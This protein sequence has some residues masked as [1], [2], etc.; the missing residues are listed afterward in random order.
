MGLKLPDIRLTGEEKPRKNLT[1]ET[2]P[3]RGSNPGP[4][5]DKRACYHLFH[6][7]GRS[8]FTLMHKL[9]MML[10]NGSTVSEM[11]SWKL[12]TKGVQSG[13]L[14]SPHKYM[15]VYPTHLF[16]PAEW[17]IFGRFDWKGWLANQLSDVS[18]YIQ[19]IYLRNNWS[20]SAAQ[21]IVH[22]RARVT[23]RV[24]GRW[25]NVSHYRR[26][27]RLIY[28]FW[29]QRS[30]ARCADSTRCTQTVQGGST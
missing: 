3:D 25:R 17:I 26:P 30:T 19:D 6:S 29:A 24:T 15:I 12:Y 8:L 23:H 10:G 21:R 16:K 9:S 5:R 27:L 4:L 1:H 20:H 28:V 11:N 14:T 7:G 2:C 18:C 13:A 22:G